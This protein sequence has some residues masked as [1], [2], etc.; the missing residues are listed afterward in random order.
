MR[1]AFLTPA[2]PSIRYRDNEKDENVHSS[3]R[4]AVHVRLF[5]REHQ[6]SAV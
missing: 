1:H 3:E 4:R 2:L 6:Y 5:L